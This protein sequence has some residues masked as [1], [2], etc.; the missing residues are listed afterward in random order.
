MEIPFSL[1]FSCPFFPVGSKESEGRM[2][3]QLERDECVL[4]VVTLDVGGRCDWGGNTI[5][6]Q[7]HALRGSFFLSR[8]WWVQR[9][10]LTHCVSNCISI[11]LLLGLELLSLSL[12]VLP[13]PTHH[14][15]LC[16]LRPFRAA[17]SYS[18]GS[19]RWIRSCSNLRQEWKQRSFCRAGRTTLMPLVSSSSFSSS[20]SSSS[21][22]HIG[23]FV[24]SSMSFHFF[25]FV[26]VSFVY[27]LPSHC[28]A[29]LRRERKSFPSSIHFSLFFFFISP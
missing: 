9:T 2:E 14:S 23:T 28:I 29:P 3:V 17:L 19:F 12:S 10:S 27:F 22:W 20:S 5:S 1:C 6:T 7:F 11:L 15:N 24:P 8:G 18:R 25:P 13:F 21:P 16:D 26:T 4:C